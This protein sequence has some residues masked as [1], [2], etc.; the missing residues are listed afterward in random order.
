MQY[1]VIEEKDISAL[2][3][4]RISTR[5]NKM[6]IDQLSQLGITIDS[7]R[8]ALLDNVKG[9]LCAISGKIVGFASG[10]KDTGEMLVIALL[11]EYEGL[12]I[13]KHL[14]TPVQD[15]L[16]AQGHQEL[17][18]TTSPVPNTRSYG[19]YRK[20]GWKAVGIMQG[21]NE[22]LKLQIETIE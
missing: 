15:W 18:L 13:G 7:T 11:P 17:W 5:E 16:F 3:Q 22:V 6:T 19:F 10:D 21:N 8:E 1:R 2:F 12:G 9:W 14:L 4:V 20:L